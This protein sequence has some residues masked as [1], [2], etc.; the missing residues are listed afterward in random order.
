MLSVTRLSVLP[1][2]G[3]YI[4][5]LI[6]L[7]KALLGMT[8]H[9][10]AQTHRLSETPGGSRIGGPP[11]SLGFSNVLKDDFNVSLVPQSPCSHIETFPTDPKP[12]FP[13]TESLCPCCPD[14][15]KQLPQILLPGFNSAFP[16]RPK[17]SSTY[18]TKSC[19][20]SVPIMSF[21]P[22]RHRTCGYTPL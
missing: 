17:S 8:R 7:W 3:L 19:R 22:D 14:S 6:S 11:S 18:I 4:C 5:L 12:Y 2:R 16:P 15:L 13:S 21:L 9:P 1:P 20:F 10:C